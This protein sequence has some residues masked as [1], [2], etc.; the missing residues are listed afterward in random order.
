MKI[1]IKLAVVI[2]ICTVIGV[3]VL[4]G[5][6]I[7]LSQR[8][9]SRLVDDAAYSLAVQSSEKIRNRIGEYMDAART[10]AKIMEGYKDIPVADRRSHF[11][12]ML[13]QV[14]ITTSGLS[15]VYAHF[16]PNALDGMDAAYA[17]TPGTDA[18][19]RFMSSWI[20][21]AATGEATLT[22]VGMDWNTTM[23]LNI[24]GDYILEP[25]NYS[26]GGE[27]FL[28]ASFGVPIKDNGGIVGYVGGSVDLSLIPAIANELKPFGDGYALVF[29]TGGIVAAHTD[30][31]RLG[32]NMRETEQDTFG[33]FLNT[34]V[35]AISSGTPA[36]FSY[37]PPNADTV[38]RY[39]SVPFTIGNTRTPWSLVVGVSQNTIMA[40]VYRML[41]I[42]LIIGVLTVFFMLGG[43]LFMARAISRPISALALLL[44][45]L[46][47]GE[48]DLTKTI[49]ITDKNEIGDLAHYF[50]SMVDK[51]K[52][53]VISIRNEAHSLSRTGG[54]LAENV[55][56]TTASIN[57]ITTNIQS[58]ASQSGQQESSAKNA[59][60][61]ME[62]VEKNIKTLNIQLQRQTDR[63]SHSSSAVEEMLANIQSVTRTLI[64]NEKHIGKLAEVSEVGRSGL[65]EMS[66]NIQ[67]VAQESE[68]L[69]EINAVMRNIASQTN[70]LSMNASIE[71]AHAGESG[72]GFAVVADE[73]R[74]LAESSAKQSKTIS[75]ALKKI[76]GSIDKITKSTEGALLQ[77]EAI[78]EGVRTVT[79]QEANVRSAME[80]Q[81]AG[82]KSILEAISDL[83]E[84]TRDVMEKAQ[85]MG[86]RSREVVKESKALEEI[87][88]KITGGM[89]EIAA[90]TEQI[91][92]AVNRVNDISGENERQIKA[93]MGE[94]SRFKVE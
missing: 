50:N 49:A 79:E 60:K 40:P 75:G 14:V 48:G 89:R 20:E 90:G 77:F 64:G 39:Y 9:I 3:S 38:M 47:E 74:K 61:T 86:G 37:H 42:S 56:E 25:F 24:T 59:E 2:S 88:G 87:T 22:T 45:D 57:E 44:K 76:K 27:S 80:E 55:K 19:G 54:E 16:A 5:V 52:R 28:V 34:L 66:G 13:K 94:V 84:I 36:S 82:S 72:K 21:V 67:E 53:L 26:L 10:I 11:D 71:A 70:L 69:L 68:G 92:H 81:D 12:R 30:P 41:G 51:I 17:N 62:E 33:P 31:A 91:S 46:S 29:S 23:Q 32:K 73:M 8:E 63:I 93:L 7:G 58:I 6:I 4:A 43:V 83:K 15:N 85:A 1:G 65:R 78:H 35:D 18:T